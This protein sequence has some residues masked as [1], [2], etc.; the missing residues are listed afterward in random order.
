MTSIRSRLTRVA[1]PAALAAALAV[2]GAGCLVQGRDYTIRGDVAVLSPAHTDELLR[3]WHGE[4]GRNWACTTNAFYR[5]NFHEQ[6]FFDQQAVADSFRVH[7]GRMGLVAPALEAAYRDL[8]L[9]IA[10]PANENR[11]W[12]TTPC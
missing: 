12:Q 7:E 11:G 9:C 4:C 1:A 3:R 5:W 6:H 10:L 8:S 2:A